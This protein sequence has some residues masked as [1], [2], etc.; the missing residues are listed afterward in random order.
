MIVTTR[1]KA[2][3]Y[4]AQCWIENGGSA[5]ANEAAPTNLASVTAARRLSM[6]GFMFTVPGVQI[7]AFAAAPAG[8]SCIVRFWWYD[9]VKDLW[10]PLGNV[11][12]VTTDS[13]NSTSQ[14]LSCMQG[15]LFHCQIVTNTNVTKMAVVVR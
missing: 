10:V 7:A 11:A 15:S 3:S 9:F 5:L 8:S 14:T 1:N 6:P 4:T 12:T 13:T 2:S